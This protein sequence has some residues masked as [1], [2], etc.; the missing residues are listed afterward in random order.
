ML[1][2]LTNKKKTVILK[3]SF[4]RDWPIRKLYRPYLPKEAAARGLMEVSQRGQLRKTPTDS[5]SGPSGE[6]C[7]EQ[8]LRQ[9]FIIVIIKYR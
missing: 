7:R 5:S 9:V 8:Q 4:G 1:T 2:N 3:Q 6:G